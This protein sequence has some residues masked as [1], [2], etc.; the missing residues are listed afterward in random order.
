MLNAG[1]TTPCAAQPLLL[2]ARATGKKSIDEF[3]RMRSIGLCL[4]LME[5]NWEVQI[6]EKRYDISAFCLCMLYKCVSV[7]V[8]FFCFLFQMLFCSMD[9][10]E[11]FVK[12]K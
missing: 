2:T 5:R 8:F 1:E 12:Q 11:Q 4:Q 6:N 10:H 7:S 9:V 3:Y